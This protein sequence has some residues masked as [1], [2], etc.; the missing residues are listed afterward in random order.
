[1]STVSPPFHSSIFTGGSTFASQIA[2]GSAEFNN[3][4]SD[5][6]LG[7]PDVAKYYMLG[8][9]HKQMEAFE[10]IFN[11]GKVDALPKELQQILRYSAYACT[12][13]SLGKA[14]DRY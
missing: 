12:A 1:M 11:K 10:V 8:S 7:F 3:P 2:N 4:S 14:F 5:I 6:I 13:D 9:H